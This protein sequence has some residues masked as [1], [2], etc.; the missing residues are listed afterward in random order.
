MRPTREHL[1]DPRPTH[2]TK[3]TGPPTLAMQNINMH[4]QTMTLFGITSSTKCKST[5]RCPL[6]TKATSQPGIKTNRVTNIDQLP[7]QTRS[8]V[9]TIGL[10]TTREAL[11]DRSTIGKNTIE[12]NGRQTV[13]I[14][15]LVTPIK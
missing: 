12:I 1:E 14:L 6:I 15:I 5:G 11:K 13:V 4:H 3:T 9:G 2:R 8:I 7:N 10:T